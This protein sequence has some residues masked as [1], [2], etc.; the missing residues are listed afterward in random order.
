[1]KY[2][3]SFTEEAVDINEI[4]NPNWVLLDSYSK[5]RLDRNQDLLHSVKTCNTDDELCV[6]ANG[7]FL[8]YD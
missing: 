3:I 8:D 6:Y 5:I 7:G 2:I 4:F 1:M